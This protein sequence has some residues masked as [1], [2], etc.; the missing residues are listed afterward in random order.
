M[1]CWHFLPFVQSYCWHQLLISRSLSLFSAVVFCY[2]H[3]EGILKKIRP[4]QISV[5]QKQPSE[6]KKVSSCSRVRYCQ[7]YMQMFSKP[8]PSSCCCSFLTLS[9]T[10][11]QFYVFFSVCLTENNGV[12][13]ICFYEPRMIINC[14]KLAHNSSGRFCTVLVT[15]FSANVMLAL[16]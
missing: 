16:C 10:N 4:K 15:V 12:V 11:S 13:L 7:L 5:R 8:G 2:K 3:D 14:Y 9:C 1:I 6:Q